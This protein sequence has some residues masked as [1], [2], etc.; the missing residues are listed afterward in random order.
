VQLAF[1]DSSW[2]SLCS[3]PATREKG[4]KFL[5]SATEGLIA[6]IRELKETPIL[7]RRDQHQQGITRDTAWT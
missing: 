3:G 4:E 6:L 5:E 2:G 1:G 7:P